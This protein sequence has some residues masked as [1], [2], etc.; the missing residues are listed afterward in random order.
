MK[1]CLEVVYR[2]EHEGSD[3]GLPQD[4][5]SSESPARELR[6]YLFILCIDRGVAVIGWNAIIPPMRFQET[7]KLIQHCYC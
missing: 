1:C 6:C 4:S 2:K 3:G 7:S 5:E